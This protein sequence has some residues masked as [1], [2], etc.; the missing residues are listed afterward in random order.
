MPCVPVRCDL[1]QAKINVAPEV[2]RV[3]SR[4]FRVI[5]CLPLCLYPVLVIIDFVFCVG[6]SEQALPIIQIQLQR[7]TSDFGNQ[8][9]LPHGNGGKSS[10]GLQK[11]FSK[12]TSRFT[13]KVS[14]GGSSSHSGSYSVPQTPSKHVLTTSN[15]E[16]KAKHPNHTDS[17]LQSMLTIGSFSRSM[18]APHSTHNA[19]SQL[20][21]GFL[22][23]RRED[24]FK[25]EELK[26][27]KGMNLPSDQEMQDVIDFLSGF[28]MGK[29]QQTSPVVKRRNSTTASVVSEQK[30]GT[31]KP[32]AQPAIHP[33]VH[34]PP[35]QQQ[36]QT[37][38]QQQQ[39]LLQQPPPL[40]LSQKQQ[41]QYYQHLFQPIGPQQ[42]PPQQQSQH[43]PGKWLS[44]S[45]QP[46][47]QAVGSGL[48]PIGQ[49]SQWSGQGVSDLSSDLYSMGL[50]SSFMDNMMSEMLGQKSQGPR[51]NTWPNRDQS[52]G[53][54]GMLGDILSFDP[55]G[56]GPCNL[57]A[58]LP[59]TGG[60][61]TG[62]QNL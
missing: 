18:D 17:K 24:L 3:E 47:S 20:V 45:N 56:N 4:Q 29:S 22:V 25:G 9:D 26:D 11:T 58:I 28:N 14:C 27:E 21:N 13:K 1:G 51:N 59:P 42:Q 8:I 10:G 7:D 60:P 23:D 35:P 31:V 2:V 62:K 52:E 49:M 55:A 36:Q 19:N 12:L 33:P 39:G 37:Q 38:P 15:S 43:P 61:E 34:P 44:T 50:V 57:W 41:L 48:S 32:P 5:H 46:S 40:Q 6:C 16:E 30:Q 53:V 54:F